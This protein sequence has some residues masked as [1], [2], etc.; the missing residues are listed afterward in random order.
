[1]PAKLS[2]IFYK[3]LPFTGNYQHWALYLSAPNAKDSLLIQVVNAHPTFE[4]SF[5]NQTPKG[6]SATYLKE[7]SLSEVQ[8]Q[9]IPHL[10]Q[11]AQAANVDNETVDWTCQDYVIEILDA[12][13]EECIIGFDGEKEDSDYREAKAEMMQLYGAMI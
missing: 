11:I 9:D 7:I 13:E 2:V 1:M 4:A 10:R 12:L 8:V 6:F 3:P 5:T